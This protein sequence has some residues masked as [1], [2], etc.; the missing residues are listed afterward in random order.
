MFSPVMGMRTA[1]RAPM[2]WQNTVGEMLFH[3]TRLLLHCSRCGFT[4]AEFSPSV[5]L[6]RGKLWVVWDATEPCPTEDCL[7]PLFYLGSPGPSTPFRPLRTGYDMEL[8]ITL[9]LNGREASALKRLRDTSFPH[10]TV[11]DVA[12]QL[13]RDSLIQCGV[14]DLPAADRSKGARRA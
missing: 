8:D 1:A 12:H 9:N 6:P 13:F 2:S 7:E 5:L 3:G 11:R 14:L 10:L 4:S